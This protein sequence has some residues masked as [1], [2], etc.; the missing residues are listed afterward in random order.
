MPRRVPLPPERRGTAFRTADAHGLSRNRLRGRDVQAPYRGIRSLG[1][2]ANSIVDRCRMF[3]PKMQA[4]DAFCSVTAALLYRMPLPRYQENDRQLHVTVA[5]RRPP[6]VR[7]IVSHSYGLTR[8]AWSAAGLPLVDP[9]ETWVH[10]APILNREDLVAVGDFLVSGRV[11]PGGRE[12][13]LSTIE[14]LTSVIES[15]SGVRGLTKLRWAVSRVRTGVDSRPESHL[16]LLFVANGLPE[17]VVNRPVYSASGVFLGRADLAYPELW[18]LFE[19]EGDYHRTSPE[20]FR[21]DIDR[22]ERF[23]DHGWRVM[24]VTSDHLYVA[25]LA[26]LRRVRQ[27]MMV[28]RSR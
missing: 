5:G 28:Q 7:G 20:Q 6:R 25:P 23:E 17:P 22:R 12:P 21:R 24:R 27:S 9:V 16:R 3:A 19:Y 18:L 8:P 11:T 13:P 15:L 10:L 2:H 26:F 1:L 14:E 4:G